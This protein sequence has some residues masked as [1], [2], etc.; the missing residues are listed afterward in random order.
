MVGKTEASGDPLRGTCSVQQLHTSGRVFICQ[1]PLI[2]HAI[3]VCAFMFILTNSTAATRLSIHNTEGGRQC[4]FQLYNVQY[5][6]SAVSFETGTVTESHPGGKKEK[7][8]LLEQQRGD[9]RF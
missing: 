9:T 6:G 8:T 5:I 3:R 7:E 2:A 4:G 1:L